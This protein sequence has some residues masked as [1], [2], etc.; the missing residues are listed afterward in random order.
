MYQLVNN[1]PRA[2]DRVGFDDELGRV[3]FVALF[4]TNG[5]LY[6]GDIERVLESMKGR[7]ISVGN[8][9]PPC[10]VFDTLYSHPKGFAYVGLATDNPEALYPYMT[11]VAAM[12]PGQL[13]FIGIFPYDGVDGDACDNQYIQV[14]GAASIESSS[15]PQETAWVIN[16]YSEMHG[17]EVATD[18]DAWRD[19]I[20]NCMFS[21]GIPELG[22]GIE[23][24]LFEIDNYLEVSDPELAVE[25]LLNTELRP[26]LVRVL[27]YFSL[28]QDL[29]EYVTTDAEVSEDGA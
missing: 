8:E 4:E 28:K 17:N 14:L 7:K 22:E 23:N 11:A 24:A 9:R 5:H 12:L 6:S 18:P 20:N 2:V 21:L 1:K 16:I 25:T 27:I 29:H 3:N 15:T 10:E 19:V 26:F 13:A